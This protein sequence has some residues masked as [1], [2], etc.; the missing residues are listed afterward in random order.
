M[1]HSRTGASIN[2]TQPPMACY[3]SC[4]GDK[5][6]GIKMNGMILHCCQD[7]GNFMRYS[8]FNKG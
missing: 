7:E 8:H 4:S 3:K 1:P 5:R 6:T 2:C